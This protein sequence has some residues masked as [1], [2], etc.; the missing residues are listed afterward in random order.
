MLLKNVSIYVL[1]TNH[2]GETNKIGHW[3]YFANSIFVLKSGQCTVEF[4]SEF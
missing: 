2:T 1:Q 4:G 3:N